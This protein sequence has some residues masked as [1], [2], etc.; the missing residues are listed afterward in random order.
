MDSKGFGG[1]SEKGL[2]TV[3]AVVFALV[4]GIGA[5]TAGS[6]AN[7]PPV[8]VTTYPEAWQTVSGFIT[9]QGLAGDDVEVVLVE[10]A[11]DSTEDW[12]PAEDFTGDWHEWSFEWDTT[13]V[14]DGEHFIVARAFDGELY[15]ELY[16]IPVN[17]LNEENHPPAVW[18]EH[19]PDF[20]EV[21]GTVEIWGHASDPDEGDEVELVQI[22]FDNTEDWINCTDVSEHGNWWIWEYIWDTTQF[23]N[24]WHYFVV[25]AW[26]GEDYSDLVDIHVYVI[27]EEEHN[28][29]PWV[30]I[31]HP[32]DWSEVSGTIVIWGHAEDPDPGDQVELVQVAFDGTEEWFNATDVSP[33]G[34]WHTWEYEWDTTQF[35]DGWHAIVARSWDG[36]LWSE[37]VDVHVYVDNVNDPPVC[38]IVEPGWEEVV[39]GVVNVWIKCFDDNELLEV[40][41]M[42]DE[43]GIW[44]EAT[45]MGMEEGYEYWMWEWDTTQWEDGIHYIHAKGWD[46]EY[47]SEIDWIKV[48]VQNGECEPPVVEIIHPIGGEEVSGIYLIH[49]EA[50]DP[51]PEH[52][53][54]VVYVRID[55]GDWHEALDT[56]WDGS[57]STWGFYWN[58]FDYENGEHVISAKARTECRCS[59]VKFREVIVHN[60]NHMPSVMIVHPEDRETVRELYLIHGKAWDDDEGDS[61]EKVQVKIGNGEW[62]MAKDASP[63]DSWYLWAF[64]WDTTEY[65]DDCY[66]IL[67]RSWDGELWSDNASVI[68]CADNIDDPPEV[69]ILYPDDGMILRGIVL[70][71]GVAEDDRG[72]ELV[73]VRIDEEE[74]NDAV[75]VSGDGSWSHWA[76]EWNTG[77]YENGNHTVCARAWDGN[78]HSELDCVKVAVDNINNP[79]EVQIVSPTENE[80]VRGEYLVYGYASDPDPGDAV[81]LVQV[82]IDDGDWQNATDTSGDG[83]WST[84]AYLWDTTQ[85]DNGNH[86]VHARSFDGELWSEVDSVNVIVDNFEGKIVPP[87]PII[88]LVLPMALGIPTA[89]AAI[90]LIRRYI[91]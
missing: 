62:H 13:L 90:I 87:P 84:W 76:F 64:E 44:Y 21:S 4:V 24:G 43:D 50:W 53:I 1:V 22:A 36:E 29:P 68:A 85:Y 52:E 49:G 39:S 47:W 9:I 34:N 51:N 80:T 63:D 73:Q 77:E 83:S 32:P 58:T 82:K 59:E 8:V 72:V 54:S 17:V 7:E 2:K 6:L 79:P 23:E 70:V 15:S 30:N 25:R 66:V 41:V 55:G 42:I 56:S 78:S 65:D 45:W 37:Y 67:A 61:I 60:E 20:S 74:W 18:V 81:E 11:I 35:E 91:H 3:I 86:T 5:L 48:I 75:D 69:G 40:L 57:W 19:P 26:D 38:E 71:N 16:D 46:G 28:N 27:N 14:E 10:V 12:Q 33:E 31:E 88:D 89:I